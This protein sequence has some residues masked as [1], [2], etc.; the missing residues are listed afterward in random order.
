[1]LF[2]RRSSTGDPSPPRKGFVVAAMGCAGGMVMLDQTVVAIALDPVARDLDLTTFVMHAIVLVYSLAMS[3]FTPVGAMASRRF[4][5]LRTFECGAAL[6]VLASGLCGLAPGGDAAEP[7]L[8]TVRAV[9]GVGAA[10][11]LPV[12]TTL[13]A[14]VYDEHE[15]GRALAVYAGLAQVFFVAGPVLGAVL[16]DFLGWRS[17]FLANVPV[18]ALTL[19]LITAAHVRRPPEGGALTAGQ[20]LAVILSLGLFIIGLYQCGIWGVTDTRTVALVVT[21]AL[22]LALTVRLVLRSG[23]PLVDLRLLL[24]R[25]Y[26]VDVT[27]TFLVQ[28]AQLIVMVHGTLFL[29]QAM[30]RSLPATGISLLPLVAGLAVGTFMSGYLLDHFRS[31]RLPALTGLAAATLGAAAWTAALPSLEYPWQLPGMVLAG[32]GMGLPVPALSAEMMRAVPAVKRT[33]A[34]VVRQT[35]RQLGGSIGLASAGAVV[36]GI[37]DNALDEAGLI[38]AG[39]TP[40]AFMVASAVLGIALLLAAMMLPKGRSAAD[41]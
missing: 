4:G 2:S 22:A 6:F 8:L 3:V 10:L 20:P 15:R 9:Q 19:W 38:S 1:M 36:L 32:I 7:Y 16:I 29:R 23:R 40:G 18:G 17:V 27:I 39:A 13:I 30:H 35:L 28:A 31:I 11:M 14:D 5:L 12:A 41:H 37:N 33:D 21:G 24:I 34:S 26:T 25:P